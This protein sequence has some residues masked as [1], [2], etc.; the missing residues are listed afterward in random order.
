MA[1]R[2]RIYTADGEIVVRDGH[3]RERS[4][5]LGENGI[6]RASFVPP[7]VH[8][9]GGAK[10]DSSDRWGVVDFQKADGQSILQVPLAEWLPEAGLTGVTRLVRLLDPC[11]G[12]VLGVE[13]RDG[14]DHPRVLLPWLC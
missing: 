6:A 1:R 7:A 14:A 11:T 4:Y 12:D 2:A 10:R 5:P 3:A 13:F 8:E 9:G